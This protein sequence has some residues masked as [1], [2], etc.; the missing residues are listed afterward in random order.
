M[1]DYNKQTKGFA[2]PVGTLIWTKSLW[3]PE[4]GMGDRKDKNFF[5]GN[6]RLDEEDMEKVKSV[7][8]AM[9]KAAFGTKAKKAK[10]PFKDYEK[11]DDEF[12]YLKATSQYAPV[13]VDTKKN[14][15]D[16][17]KIWGGSKGR[18]NGILETY[19]MDNGLSLGVTY[20]LKAVQITELHTGD[21]GDPLDGFGEID[22][23]VADEG[24]ATA[25]FDTEGEDGL[26]I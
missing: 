13:I 4:P 7:L 20:R 18:I 14:P 16:P 26:D 19:F 8:D 23:F 22:G 1:A 5:V 24:D 11:G 17:K 9:N 2:T 25:G 10:I 3:K 15:V 6:I 12:T 21:G